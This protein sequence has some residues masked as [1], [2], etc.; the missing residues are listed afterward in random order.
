MEEKNSNLYGLIQKL[1]NEAEKAGKFKNEAEKENFK[2]KTFN[3]YREYFETIK[4]RDSSLQ[5]ERFSGRTGNYTKRD[6]RK[7]QREGKKNR[8]ILDKELK[9]INDKINTVL[10]TFDLPEIGGIKRVKELIQ[11]AYNCDKYNCDKLDN[12]KRNTFCPKAS[13][14]PQEAAEKAAEKAA[15]NVQTR[16]NGHGI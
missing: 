7:K 13:V 16:E 11:Y 15:E 4:K 1:V 9:A 14:N 3:L 10:D 8:K 5:D 2:D 6:V 12:K